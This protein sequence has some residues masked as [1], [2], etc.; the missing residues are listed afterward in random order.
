MYWT[1]SVVDCL[2]RTKIIN[3][4]IDRTKTI[5]HERKL[6]DRTEHSAEA[7]I[8]FAFE[9]TLTCAVL[10]MWQCRARITQFA[11]PTE[12]TMTFARLVTITV[13]HI[14]ARLTNRCL[15]RER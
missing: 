5:K 8:T 13:L 7:F 11:R 15:E 2:N 10:T 9:R 3:S 12:P 14:A 4:H 6:T 1:W